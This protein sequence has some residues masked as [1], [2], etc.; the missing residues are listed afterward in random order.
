MYEFSRYLSGTWKCDDAL[1]FRL[2]S[3]VSKVRFRYRC[4]KKIND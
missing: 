4:L 2:R 1:Q 3:H